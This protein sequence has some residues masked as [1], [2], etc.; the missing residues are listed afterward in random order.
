MVGSG[1]WNHAAAGA[2]PIWQ[3]VVLLHCPQLVSVPHKT[4][5]A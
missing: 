1:G 4:L 2:L 3:A 5:G